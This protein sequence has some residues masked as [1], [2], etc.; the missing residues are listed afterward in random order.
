[1]SSFE[2]NLNL[3]SDNVLLNANKK[4]GTE[5]Q[6]RLLQE[7]CSELITAISHF[8]RNRKGSNDELLEEL[9]D[10]S[11]VLKQIHY[12]LIENKCEEKFEDILRR[13]INRV[14]E[15]LDIKK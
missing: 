11:I 7:E 2:K 3:I 4:W 12:M 15:R 13:K 5:L 9:A 1:M 10:V 14:K 8:F 6:L